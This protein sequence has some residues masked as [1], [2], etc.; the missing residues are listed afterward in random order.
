[1]RPLVG[2]TF[3]TTEEGAHAL[4]KFYTSVCLAVLLLALML[5]LAYHR[6]RPAPQ[7]A[8]VSSRSPTPCRALDTRLMG[9]PLQANV[10]TPIQ[11]GGV[12]TGGA[13]CG[14]PTTAAGAALNFTIAQPQGPGWPDG[15]VDRSPAPDIG[16]EL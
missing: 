13:N 12:T 11:I 5:G 15:L 1:M 16:G 9:T 2:S 7:R 4:T 14:V 10:P 6:R 8:G 3:T